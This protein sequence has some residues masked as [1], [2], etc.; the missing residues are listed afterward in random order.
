MR[1]VWII[2]KEIEIASSNVFLIFGH[3][4]N[5]FLP[6]REVER[7]MTLFADNVTFWDRLSSYQSLKLPNSKSGHKKMA[8]CV[9]V[10]LHYLES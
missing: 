6:K 2:S 1:L 4:W 5:L 10:G 7:D 3:F 8:S 9:T